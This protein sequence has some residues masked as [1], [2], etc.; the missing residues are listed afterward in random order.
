MQNTFKSIRRTII[1]AIISNSTPSKEQD[2]LLF[3]PILVNCQLISKNLKK[4]I[5]K[6]N[7][8][9]NKDASIEHLSHL[10]NWALFLNAVDKYVE[11]RSGDADK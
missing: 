9:R 6:L 10:A 4:M 2:I 11:V 5:K 7:G 1:I 3:A 8:G